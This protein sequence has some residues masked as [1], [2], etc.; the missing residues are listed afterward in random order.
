VLDAVLSLAVD[1]V[2]EDGVVEAAADAKG[3]VVADWVLG[4]VDA[5]C[6]MGVVDADVLVEASEVVEVVAGASR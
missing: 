3:V 1:A 5:A 2:V 6:A 4:V